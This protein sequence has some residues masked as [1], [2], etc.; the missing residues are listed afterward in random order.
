MA[1]A[2]KTRGANGGVNRV[3]GEMNFVVIPRSKME[4][5]EVTVRGTTPLMLHRFDT[6]CI[7]QNEKGEKVKG[8]K[9]SF[10][11]PKD[12]FERARHPFPGGGDGIPAKMFKASTVRA[13][14]PVL[15]VKPMTQGRTAF[16]VLGKMNVNGDFVLKIKPASR[17]DPVMDERYVRLSGPGRTPQMRYRPLFHEGWEATLPIKYDTEQITVQ[18]LIAGL[19]KAG[20][21]L[22]IGEMRPER[23]GDTF[24]CFEIIS[25]DGKPIGHTDD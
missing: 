17:K 12:A 2:R 24:G 18:Q 21:V 16:H 15:D 14:G 9:G 6:K 5:L 8:T 3:T 13:L 10:V 1:T 23:T 7:L 25:I 11:K 20:E 22:G 19:V 4:S